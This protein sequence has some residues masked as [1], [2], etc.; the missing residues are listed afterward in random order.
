MDNFNKWIWFRRKRKKT[1]ITIN[2]K[3]KSGDLS[4]GCYSTRHGPG[5]AAT[6]DDGRIFVEKRNFVEWGVFESKRA[7][8]PNTTSAACAWGVALSLY[9]HFG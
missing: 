7:D 9:V 4:F 3:F 2:L 6:T 8:A 1:Q 5:G